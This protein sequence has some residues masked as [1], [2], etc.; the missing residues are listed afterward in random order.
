MNLVT[1]SN[2]TLSPCMGNYPNWPDS[3]LLCGYCQR[4]VVFFI[5]GRKN[6]GV[7]LE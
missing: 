5:A 4:F 3:T 7:Y 6:D 2:I 1:L